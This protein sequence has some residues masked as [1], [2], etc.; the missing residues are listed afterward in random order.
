MNIHNAKFIKSAAKPTDFIIPTSGIVF[1]K[2]MGKSSVINRFLNRKNFRVS[3]T[4]A[5]R[6]PLFP[7]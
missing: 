5:R 3:N 4:P 6:S 1:R 7:D 2:S